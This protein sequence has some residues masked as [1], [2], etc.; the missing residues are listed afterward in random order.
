M[1]SFLT[2]SILLAILLM[3]LGIVLVATDRFPKRELALAWTKISTG[4]SE[5]EKEQEPPPEPE[6]VPSFEQVI[7]ERAIQAREIER[8]QQE[9]KN[10]LELAEAKQKEI[11]GRR[12]ALNKLQQDLQ[13]GYEQ[14][15]E[16]VVKQG[17][18]NLLAKVEAMAPKIAKQFLLDQA[19]T[20]EQVSLE[21]IK[22]LDPVQAA[23]IFKE[24][25]LPAEVERLNE[26]LTKIGQ[27]EPEKSDLQAAKPPKA[28]TG[29]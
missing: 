4:K 20:D 15:Q 25:K 17:R 16:E 5:L 12:Q 6:E 10:L 26:L 23:K 22:K 9:V 3:G 2:F 8:R 18:Q 29:S 24:F 21:L 1:K 14:K 19:E 11:E 13:K 27:G 28:A 7:R